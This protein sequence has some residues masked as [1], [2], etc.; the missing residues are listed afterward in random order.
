MVERNPDI[1]LCRQCELLQ[2]HRSGLYYS[3]VPESDENLSIMRHMDKLY[4]DAPFYGIRRVTAWLNEKDYHVNAKRV[5]RLMNVMGWQTIYRKPN[6]SKP[7]KQHPVYPY[8]LK[9][10]VI[11]HANQVWAIDITYIPMRK[12]FM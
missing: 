11:D 5:R 12:G 2:I 6:T 7:D 4:L 9:N 10:L 3:P 1:S 8:L